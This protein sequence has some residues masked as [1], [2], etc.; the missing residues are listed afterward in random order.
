QAKEDLVF[1]AAKSFQTPNTNAVN[2]DTPLTP[3]TPVTPGS[4]PF[5]TS[6]SPDILSAGVS[7][8][9]YPHPSTFTNKSATGIPFLKD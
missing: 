3:G 7:S 5:A 2:P 8:L 4:A 1:S 9:R 6:T